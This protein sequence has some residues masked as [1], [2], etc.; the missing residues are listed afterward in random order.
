M[1]KAS[2]SAEPDPA[3][4]RG[5]GRPA[6]ERSESVARRVQ[7]WAACGVR[8]DDIAELESMSPPTLRRLYRP[9]LDLGATRANAEAAQ[10]LFRATATD[11]RA[12]LAWLKC[13]A[14]WIE[15]TAPPSDP[16]PGKKAEAEAF[17]LVAHRH[18]DWQDL[19][20]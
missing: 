14:G 18:T 16:Q 6:L 8:I 11:W 10:R 3:L 17:G 15:A 13:R 2:R 1:P 20:Q 12:A 7:S 19:L 9:E 4:K 5:R